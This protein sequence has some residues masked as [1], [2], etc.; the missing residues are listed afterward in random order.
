MINNGKHKYVY[1][2]HYVMYDWY[3]WVVI[4]IVFHGIIAV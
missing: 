1:V 3:I 2:K 4:Y